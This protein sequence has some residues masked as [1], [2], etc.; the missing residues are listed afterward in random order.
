M[1]ESYL[2]QILLLHGL[3]VVVFKHT[4]ISTYASDK[5]HLPSIPIHYSKR[6][7]FHTDLTG[8]WQLATVPCVKTAWQQHRP[9]REKIKLLPTVPGE[10]WWN[11]APHHRNAL[12]HF[13]FLGPECPKPLLQPVG[14]SANLRH[15]LL[16]C[17]SGVDGELAYQTHG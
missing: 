17:R 9:T 10:G 2:L 6:V 5:A 16:L 7:S 12:L 14:F 11:G 1:L 4:A 3:D 15:S 8:L 13:A